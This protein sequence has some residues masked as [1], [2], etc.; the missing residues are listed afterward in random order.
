MKRFAAPAVPG[1]TWF[2]AL[3][4]VAIT[5]AVLLGIDRADLINQITILKQANT[6]LT[7]Q[8]RGVQGPD[9]V[10]GES[11]YDIAV[12]LGF[13][14]TEQEWLDSLKGEP[15]QDGTDGKNGANGTPGGYSTIDIQCVSNKWKLVVNGTVTRDLNVYCF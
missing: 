3:G 1:Y 4:I 9:G 2:A 7:T 5:V 12:R 8:N 10:D 11:A 15:G 13:T 6:D 14:G